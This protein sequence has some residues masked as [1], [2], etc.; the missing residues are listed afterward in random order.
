MKLKILVLIALICLGI[1]PAG[2]QTADI[3]KVPTIDTTG[4]AEI[5]VV[6]DEVSFSLRITKSDKTLQVAKE[7]NDVNVAKIIALTK[8]FAIDSKDVKTDYI[9]VSEKFDRVKLKD[10]DEYQNVFAG[11]TVSK[12]VVVKLRDLNKFEEFFSEIIKIGVTQVSNVSFQS[13]ELRKYKDQARAMAIRAA[14]EKA[15]AIAKEI[16]Q[17]IGKAVS[18]DEED[19]DENRNSNLNSNNTISFGIYDVSNAQTISV[20]T[21]G[22][23]AQVNAKFLLY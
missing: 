6:P 12:T 21:I 5:Q 20:G 17:T 10:D 11:Y 18:I 19:L 22:V 7:Q 16:G 13:S 14:K 2:A 9:S 4:T 1:A 23:K 3:S 8:R 15:E